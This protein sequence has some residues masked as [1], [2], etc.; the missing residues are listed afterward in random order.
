[1]KQK[2]SK[3][4]AMKHAKRNG[5]QVDRRG[6]AFVRRVVMSKKMKMEDYAS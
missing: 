4:F 1:M 6:N 2:V 3:K 5:P